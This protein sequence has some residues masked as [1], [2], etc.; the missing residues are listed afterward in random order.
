MID[1]DTLSGKELYSD[2]VINAV[3][4]EPDPVTR[5]QLKYDLMDHAEAFGP[6]IVKRVEQLLKIAEKDLQQKMK[7]RGVNVDSDNYTQFGNRY[8]EMRCG[9]WEADLQGI[10]NPAAPEAE[11]KVCS[12]PILPTEIVTNIDDGSQKVRLAWLRRGRWQEKLADRGIISN[13]NKITEL[14]SFGVDVTSETARGL[15][16]YLSDIENLNFDDIPEI[17]A[18]ARM[19]WMEDGFM[20]YTSDLTFDDDGRFSR[21]YETLNEYGDPAAWYR[22]V[23]EIRK[24]GR[25]EPRAAMAVS[26]ASVLIKPC[27]LLPFWFDIWGQS[28]GG[29]SVCGM[30]AASIWADPEIGK[31]IATFDA[32]KVGFDVLCG[33]L[34][35]LPL[36]IDDTAQIRKI[37]KDDFSPMVYKLASGEGRTRSNTNL[38]IA[39]KE[40]WRNAIF[41]TGESPIISDSMQGG[42]VN[43]ILEYETDSGDIFQD[44]QGAAAFLRNNYGFAGR[45]FI[46][47]L[48]DIGLDTAVK[49]QRECF[50]SIRDPAYEDKQLLSL[51]VLLTADRIAA[52]Y[53]FKDGIYLSFADLEK[54]LTDKNTLSEHARCYDYLLNECSINA[55]RFQTNSFGDYSGEVWGRYETAPDGSEYVLIQKN[56]FNRLCAEGGFSEKAFLSWAAKRRLILRDSQGKN[57]VP[58]R[59]ASRNTRCVCLKCREELPEPA[60]TAG[61]DDI[62]L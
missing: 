6:K 23:G 43:R 25:I 44:G 29:K 24:S 41:C 51:S 2:A 53:L 17:R 14:A 26:F 19:G 33:F 59:I 18:T 46:R 16:K 56:I 58:K 34:N 62:A 47:L 27:G 52:D 42:A 38:G 20:P 55:N 12:H 48:D 50:E 8:P 28:G 21:V 60:D 9:K 15:V 36:I 32:T 5:E 13:K 11:R 37:M 45:E 7:G 1:L 49:L 4:D 30:L 57:T 35:H 31:Y 10:R 61:E 22:F 3:M 54:A 39:K 40:T